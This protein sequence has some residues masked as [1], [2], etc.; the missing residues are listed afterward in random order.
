[1]KDNWYLL[2]TE[3][4]LEKLNVDKNGLTNKEVKSNQEK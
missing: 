3:E 4:V 2:D 1:M